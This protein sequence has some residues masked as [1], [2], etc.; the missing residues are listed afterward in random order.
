MFVG[1][2]AV[3]LTAK[4]FAPRAPFVLLFAAPLLL[5]LIWPVF[6]LLGWERV[7]VDPGNTAFTQLDFVSYPWTHSLLMA[8]L[9]G[10]AAGGLCWALTRD[11]VA[12]SLVGLG[13]VSHWVLDW[14]SHRP[15]L[16]LTPWGVERVGLG[17][18][19]SIPGTLIGEGLLFAVGI[20]VYLGS[21]RARSRTGVVAFWS[22]I[23]VV[24]V[25]WSTSWASPPPPS[26]K[27]V[28]VFAFIVWLMPAWASWFDR[29]R[30]AVV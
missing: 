2:L 12:T 13:V 4:R 8:F 23:A 7:A 19:N 11:R 16:P 27:A 18:W 9:W 15:D 20:W 10:V 30:D 26:A 1:H 5:D 6:L 22:F 24:T 28:A 17:L 3:G 25:M 14:I 29:H 21:T